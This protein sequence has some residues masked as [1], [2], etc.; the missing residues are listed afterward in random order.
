MSEKQ[1]FLPRW[2]SGEV[3]MCISAE[4]GDNSHCGGL[5]CGLPLY[6]HVVPH[7]KAMRLLLVSEPMFLW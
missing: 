2:Q 6:N 1:H 7:G 5:V 3:W 4:P